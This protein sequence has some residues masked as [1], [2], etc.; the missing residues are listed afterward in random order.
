M[1]SS[2]HTFRIT[3][4]SPILMN[5]P[6]S[7]QMGRAAGVGMKKIPTPE[8]EAKAKVYRNS[9]GLY[10]P[11]VAFRSSIIGRG[12][13]AS[14]RKIGKFTANSRVAAGAFVVDEHTP[15]VHVKTGKPIKDYEIY[16]CRAVVQG[17]GVRRSRPLIKDWACDLKLEVDDDFV[18]V[19]QLVDLLNMSGKVAGIM[20]FRPQCKGSFGRY[21]A[22]LK[23]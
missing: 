23:S 11:S 10:I 22:E 7:M 1:A 4:L 19:E 14:G 9:K 2:V 20:D 13:G 21:E 18:T 17:N 16:S 5:N 12:G 8:E 3:G 15:L 6:E